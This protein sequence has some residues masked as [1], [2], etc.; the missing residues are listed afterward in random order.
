MQR[1]TPFDPA[2]Y[3]LRKLDTLLEQHSLTREDVQWLGTNDYK[4]TFARLSR[5][6]AATLWETFDGLQ[7][8]GNS[9]VI[10]L[11]QLHDQWRFISL[12]EPYE[13]GGN[14]AESIR[15]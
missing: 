14:D 3:L 10:V 2:A 15:A 13:E 12:V 4:T 6:K 7:I 5:A 8:V 9:F 11:E 1:I